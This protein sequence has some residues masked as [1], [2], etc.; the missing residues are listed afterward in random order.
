[1]I[2]SIM[3]SNEGKKPGNEIRFGNW[4]EKDWYVN[5]YFRFLRQ[6]FDA[7]YKGEIEDSRLTPYKSLL[8]GQF[9]IL[10]V[11][12]YIA[13]GLYIDLIFIDSPDKIF[14][15][16]VYSEVD[17]VSETITGDYTLSGFRLA[18][19]P[20]GITKAEILEIVQEHPENKLW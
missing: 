15:T 17:E 3:Q 8:N 13:G 9:S 16:S 7:S 4:T 12:P 2:D 20:S 5:D 10:R 11:G 14:T 19:E 1:M 6:Y 18:E